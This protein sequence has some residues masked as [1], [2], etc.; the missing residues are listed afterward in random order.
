MPII[1][2]VLE[3]LISVLVRVVNLFLGHFQST[4]AAKVEVVKALFGW[5]VHFALTYSRAQ[6]T[7]VIC[8]CFHGERFKPPTVRRTHLI[9][10]DGRKRP[11]HLERLTMA[12][13]ST[14]LQKHKTETWVTSVAIFHSKLRKTYMSA[15]FLK[16]WFCDIS[17]NVY[18]GRLR[19]TYMI[20]FQKVSGSLPQ[21]LW[22]RKDALSESS[23]CSLCPGQ[24]GCSRGWW[25]QVLV[26]TCGWYWSARS[27]S[28]S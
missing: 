14:P 25:I 19:G 6:Q 26:N 12:R 22:K 21:L 13:W 8:R 16:F 5:C 4:V 2:P 15:I 7:A 11:S 9:G 1:I 28:Y 17:W 18:F 27:T 20:S 24:E 23:L 10:Q 3:F